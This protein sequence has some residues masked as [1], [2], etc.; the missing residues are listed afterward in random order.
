[1][2]RVAVCCFLALAAAYVALPASRV[3]AVAFCA[4]VLLAACI[5][6]RAW[7]RLICRAR[8]THFIMR[9]DHYANQRDRST[10]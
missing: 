9:A 5:A 6:I 3:E 1:M 4:L 10:R 8:D 2:D 7:D